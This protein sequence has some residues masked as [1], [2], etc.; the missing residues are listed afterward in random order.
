MVIKAQQNLISS[1]LLANP[2]V[3]VLDNETADIKIISEVP[4]QQLTETSGGG[5]LGTTSFKDVGVKLKVTPHLTRDEKI[6]LKV[7]PEFSVQTGFVTFVQSGLGYPQPIVDTRNAQTTLLVD[8]GQTIVLGGLRKK[9]VQKQ[10]NKVPL[11]GDIPIICYLFRFEG[12]NTVN[13]E[14][15]VFITPW[16]V[17]KPGLNDREQKQFEST[18]FPGPNPNMTRAEKD[19]QAGKVHN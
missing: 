5:S 14:M 15:V 19:A 6:R 16:I 8:N 4:Y 11:L 10:V 2:R 7:I 9:E 12:E 13:S 17:T 3:L 1:K 18:E